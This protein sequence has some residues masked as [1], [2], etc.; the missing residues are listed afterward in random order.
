[1]VDTTV[2]SRERHFNSRPHK[3]V[4]APL[5][6]RKLHCRHISIH[7]LT[8]RS[9][10]LPDM[11]YRM[12]SY[13]NSR[14]HKEVDETSG[15]TLD[16]LRTFQFTTSQGG[17]QLRVSYTLLYPSFQF[18]TSQGGRLKKLFRLAPF[19]TFQ[20]TTSQGGRLR[21]SHRILC[22]VYF[23]SRPHKEVD[24]RR[25]TQTYRSI[26]SIHD[27][28]RRSTDVWTLRR[29]FHGQFQ[30]TTSQGGRLEEE[31]EVDKRIYFN[32]R[33]HKEVDGNDQRSGNSRKNFNS[34]PHK[35]VDS[36]R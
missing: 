2:S 16:L 10:L 6:T 17:R 1:M 31:R 15:F 23:N 12:H 9:T 36:G 32:S 35:E 13:F 24:N 21:K 33:P 5:P 28:T 7:D 8:R 14:P 4:D 25:N 26:I 18:T 3:E 19:H 29:L 20:F 30:F 11:R 27:L 34:R 22:E